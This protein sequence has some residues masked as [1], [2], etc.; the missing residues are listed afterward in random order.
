MR[1]LWTISSLGSERALE[2]ERQR[3]RSREP[4]GQRESAR[5]LSRLAPRGPHAGRPSE[6]SAGYISDACFEEN[7]P[8]PFGEGEVTTMSPRIKPVRS[9]GFGRRT[10]P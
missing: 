2:L 4:H 5:A 8:P 1:I 7:V 9:S 3:Q 6:L 10:H